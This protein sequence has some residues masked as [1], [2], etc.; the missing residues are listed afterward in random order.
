[1]NNDVPDEV[2]YGRRHLANALMD[3]SVWFE[4]VEHQHSRLSPEKFIINHRF[5]YESAL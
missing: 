4:E 1:M 3:A 5:L 2:C